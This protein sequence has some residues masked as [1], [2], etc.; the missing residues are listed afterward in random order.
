MPSQ[1]DGSARTIA[2]WLPPGELILNERCSAYGS[3]APVRV[4]EV[5]ELSC[6]WT[7]QTFSRRDHLFCGSLVKQ[8]RAARLGRFDPR[9]CSDSG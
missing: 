4:Q 5:W 9:V 2:P 1:R 6:G 3:I 7:K 8:C